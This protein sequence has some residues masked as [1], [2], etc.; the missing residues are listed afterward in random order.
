MKAIELRWRRLTLMNSMLLSVRGHSIDYC[1]QVNIGERVFVLMFNF[2]NSFVMMRVSG[3]DEFADTSGS[4][5]RDASEY[6]RS[7]KSRPE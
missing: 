1:F 4:L 6:E 2:N 5:T 3:V 7:N